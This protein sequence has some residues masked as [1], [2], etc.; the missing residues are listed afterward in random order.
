MTTFCKWLKKK[1][2]KKC[3]T[4]PFIPKQINRMPLL[5][6][7]RDTQPCRHTILPQGHEARQPL[8][9]RET[10]K[11]IT[12]TYA[13]ASAL[14]G[15]AKLF[16]ANTLRWCV[17]MWACACVFV[18][19]CL[20]AKNMRA[21]PNSARAFWYMALHWSALWFTV[22]SRGG[23]RGGRGRRGR[24]RRS[25]TQFVSQH[26]YDLHKTTICLLT[27]L[28]LQCSPIGQ[29]LHSE[30]LHICLVKLQG[31]FSGANSVSWDP[32]Q[33]QLLKTAVKKKTPKIKIKINKDQ[34]EYRKCLWAM[35]MLAAAAGSQVIWGILHSRS[36][37]GCRSPL[38][39]IKRR[40]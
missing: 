36:T 9:R 25:R 21:C 35:L 23:G 38:W 12:L 8:C 26:L 27:L 6:S 16:T 2:R 14:C 34:R 15:V 11:T 29:H 33:K 39:G 7:S 32:S 3:I 30:I 19:V 4:S 40:T 20:Y 18:R 1:E 28:T 13:P 22:Q 24:K 17:F 10:K 37:P 5:A 31:G